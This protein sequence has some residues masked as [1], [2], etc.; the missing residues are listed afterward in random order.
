MA[1][2]LYSELSQHGCQE[3]LASEQFMIIMINLSYCIPGYVLMSRLNTILVALKFLTMIQCISARD[4]LCT[5]FGYIYSQA[6]ETVSVIFNFT[7]ACSV[8]HRVQTTWFIKVRNMNPRKSSVFQ[9][10][11]KEEGD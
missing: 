4:T 3:V 7:L 1:T 2:P 10:T 9:E 8:I 6:V 5:L 11:E